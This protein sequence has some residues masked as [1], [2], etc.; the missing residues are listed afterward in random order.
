V[1]PYP[2]EDIFACKR[3]LVK[4]L[5]HVPEE[6]YVKWFHIGKNAEVNNPA[7]RA[8]LIDCIGR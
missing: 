8:G 5:M 3:V 1:E 2:R 6:G 7:H 4:G